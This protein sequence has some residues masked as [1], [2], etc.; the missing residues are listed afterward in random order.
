MALTRLLNF[1]T[2]VVY[3]PAYHVP[4]TISEVQQYMVIAARCKSI[5]RMAQPNFYR[6]RG[7]R[8]SVNLES[9]VILHGN[10]NKVVH[11]DTLFEE[12]LETPSQPKVDVNAL[13]N[14]ILTDGMQVSTAPVCI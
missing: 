9:A 8:G 12:P 11:G 1:I 10:M 14:E 3:T 7:S 4:C 5:N 6:H 2:R 13:K